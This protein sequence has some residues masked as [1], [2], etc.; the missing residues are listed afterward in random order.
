MMKPEADVATM[1]KVERRLCLSKEDM[2]LIRESLDD[3]A[4]RLETV[5][6]DPIYSTQERDR[7]REKEARIRSIYELF[8]F[9][10]VIRG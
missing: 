8:L 3:T 2:K 9:N 1:Y 4:R 5:A 6:G 10:S 7:C